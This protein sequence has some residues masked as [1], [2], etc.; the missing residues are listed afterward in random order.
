[1]SEVEMTAEEALAILKQ[2][3]SFNWLTNSTLDTWGIKDIVDQLKQGY[4]PSASNYM[5]T[6]WCKRDLPGAVFFGG[7]IGWRIPRESL[8]IF[9]AKL[10]S[11]QID[12]S[13]T[14]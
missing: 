14:G 7:P 3:K 11:G 10:A 9:F 4:I 8:L 6:N 1:M 13:N 5:V 12:T 2:Y